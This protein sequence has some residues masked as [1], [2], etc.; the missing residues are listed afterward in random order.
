MGTLSRALRVVGE[1]L[2][3]GGGRSVGCGM[4]WRGAW[5]S[6]AWRGAGFGSCMWDRVLVPGGFGMDWK[7]MGCGGQGVL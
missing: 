3:V 6:G 4:A 5:Y 2:W 1:E 7:R